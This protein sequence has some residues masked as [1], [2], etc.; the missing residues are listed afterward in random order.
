MYVQITERIRSRIERGE[1][2]PHDRIPPELQLAADLSVSRG[3]VRQAM[4]LLVRDGLLYRIQG[5]GTFVSVDAKTPETRVI[6][7]IAPYRSDPL[8]A[9]ILHG[10]EQVLTE[11][12]VGIVVLHSEHTPELERKLLERL[13]QH[14]AEG[15]ILFPLAREGEYI[16]LNSTLPHGFPVVVIDRR[17]RGVPADTV[18]SDNVEGGYLATRHLLDLGHRK[19][20]CVTIPDRPSSV[21]DRIRG[22]E[23]AM[24]ESGLFPL[25]AVALSGSGKPTNTVPDYDREDFAAID[26]LFQSDAR[27][28]AVFCVNDFVAIGLMRHLK[29]A[30]VSVPGD[31]SIVGFDDIPLAAFHEVSLTTIAQPIEDIGR[32]AARLLL[33][34]LQSPRDTFEEVLIPTS[35]VERST[36][37]EV[38]VT[39]H[40]DR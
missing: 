31:V 40:P 3:T 34:R 4:D 25:A 13:L 26:R 22:Y 12:H 39:A 36:T 20:V 17:L 8:T 5:K 38:G 19:I 32:R 9:G 7:F 30:S 37:T 14:G 16:D 6:G 21:E 23:M 18:T 27:P 29:D 33:D 15:L 1:L 35:L 11:E 10:A 2:R 24:H 28:T